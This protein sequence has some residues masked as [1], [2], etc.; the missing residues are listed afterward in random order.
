MISEAHLQKMF[1]LSQKT[2]FTNMQRRLNTNLTFRCICNAPPTTPKAMKTAKKLISDL[3]LDINDIVRLTLETTEALGERAIGLKRHEML[4][5]LRKVMAAGVRAVQQAEHT[6]SFEEATRQSVEA[7]A[8]RRPATRRDLRHFCARMLRIE[9][10]GTLP[11]RSMS[12]GDCHRILTAAFGASAHSYR[13]GRAIL[14]SIFAF[15]KRMQWCDSNPVDNIEIPRVQ[16]HEIVPLTLPEVEQLERAATLPEHRAMRTSLHLMLY[17]GLRPNEVARLQRQD[18]Q[19]QEKRVLVHPRTSKTGGGRVVPL[20]K[21]ARLR[22]LRLQIPRNWQNRWKA[23]RRAAGFT[24]W[25][26]DVC[27]HTFASYHAAHFKNLPELQLEMG[28]SSPTLLRS[29]YLNLPR[30]HQA[31]LFWS[32]P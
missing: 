7:R 13:K 24:R 17:C 32:C 30:T 8:N 16:E 3:P 19:L 22:N 1:V 14:H 5:L 15:G 23:L 12:T 6:V 10:T 27:R 20:R 25:V 4:Q 28:H 29:R 26:P 9:G 18:I 21:A 11:L 31:A 2:D